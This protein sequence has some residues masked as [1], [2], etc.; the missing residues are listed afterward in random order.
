MNISEGGL[1]EYRK[2]E[3]FRNNGVGRHHNI[4]TGT[5]FLMGQIFE[6]YMCGLA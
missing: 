2:I 3:L 4:G 5:F 1:R 6:A